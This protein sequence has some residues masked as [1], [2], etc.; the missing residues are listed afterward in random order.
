MSRSAGTRGTPRSGAGIG[1]GD[2]LELHAD[3]ALDAHVAGAP[4]QQP[5]ASDSSE[6]L[7]GRQRSLALLQALEAGDD[8]LLQREDARA[9]A[10]AELFSS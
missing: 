1:A 8:L 2:V 9:S 4:S 6:L 5:D 3:H 7:A 10:L